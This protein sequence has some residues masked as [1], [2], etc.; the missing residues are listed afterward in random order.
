MKLQGI[1][2]ALTTPFKEDGELHEQKVVENVRKLNGSG[3]A[4]Y[5]VNGSTGET[6]MLSVD[7]RV[8][9]LECVRDAS[10]DGKILIAGL[11]SDSVFESVRIAGIAAEMGYDLALALTPFYYR[12]QMQRPETQTRYYREL[13]DRSKIPLLLYNMPGV[14]GYDLPVAVIS[15]LSRHPN[16][17]GIKDSS[18]N[19]DKLRQTIGAVD[20]GFHVFSGSGVNFGEALEAGAAGAILAIA[21]AVPQ[22]TVS[23][24]ETFRKGEHEQ[25]CGW[26]TRISPFARLIATKYG[27]PGIKY[28]MD[29]NGFYGGAPRSPFA[30]PSESDRVEIAGTLQGLV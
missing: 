25:A 6:P 7:E 3:L 30:P 5:A 28:A 1:F 29:L 17:I 8:R 27:I 20:N 11:A 23:V 13:A 4:G 24:W 12:N 9:V 15:E 22:A 16:I 26:R 10:A 19:L 2:T 21:N 14:T 18:G